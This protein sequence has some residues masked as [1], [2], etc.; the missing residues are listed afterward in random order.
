[1]CASLRLQILLSFLA[2]EL[3]ARYLPPAPTKKAKTRLTL[4]GICMYR[5]NRHYNP[6]FLFKIA[7]M[8]AIIGAAYWCNHLEDKDLPK[9]GNAAAVQD[10]VKPDYPTVKVQQ[11][12][13]ITAQQHKAATQQTASLTNMRKHNMR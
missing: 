13:A 3:L 5:K 2:L 1:M 9:L 7:A 11:P 12:K 6:P 8:Y 10:F 4:I